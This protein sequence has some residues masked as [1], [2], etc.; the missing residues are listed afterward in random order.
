MKSPFAAARLAALT[1]LALGAPALASAADVPDIK[2]AV[3][4]S[5]RWVRSTQ[6]PQNGSY[7]GSAE[8][9]AWVL[10]AL[11]QSPR[12]YV[13][14]DGPFIARAVDFLLAA[15][16][17]DGSLG[18]GADQAQAT[19]V[20]AAAFGGMTTEETQAGL[21]RALAWLGKAGVADPFAPLVDAA[22][23][24]DAMLARANELLARQADGAWDG[25]Q[26]KVRATAE[27]IVE[28][29]GYY[30]ALKPPATK[31]AS[32]PLPGFDAA[33]RD[34]VEQARLRGA[35]FLQRLAD[36]GRFGAPGTPDCGLTAMSIA[37]LQTLPEP[38][39][40]AM[41]QTIDAGLEW[42][43]SLQ[44]PNGAIHDGKLASYNTSAS[45]LA[46]A[47]SAH[48]DA[49][50]AI[51]RGRD[52]LLG[53]QADAGEGYDEDHHYFGGIGYGGDERPDLSNLQMALEALA[54]SGLEQDHEGFQN[55]LKFLQRCQNRS[56]SNDLYLTQGD[57][58]YVAGDDG[59]ASYM[60]GN[61][62]AGY[63]E[64]ADG[65]K[66]ARSY[67]SMSYA[68]LKGLIFAGVPKDDPRMQACF[69]WIQKNYSLDVNPGFEAVSDP[70]AAYQGLF[71]YFHVM[72]RA[73]DLYGTDRIVTSDGTSHAWR[74]ELCG[75]LLALQSR[76]DGS[77]L[78]ENSPR[79]WEGNPLLAT[80]Y[81]LLTLDAALPE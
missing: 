34:A 51:R 70:R 9:T 68:L 4:R 81:A 27:T 25:P 56:E 6:D 69:E 38:R 57:T 47:G 49:S 13:P 66:V 74:N 59:G 36:E 18:S 52:F 67:G 64:L 3:D 41:Q 12:H 42:L 31:T 8:T 10:C 23:E 60:P 26:G 65:R 55:A 78:N 72:A 80:A 40:E 54:A 24:R 29:S 79:W 17:E 30:T 2:G 1:L 5:I 32:K 35:E 16:N 73:L 33:N 76:T 39:P 14:S 19:R 20:L 28:L 22:S 63:V 44:Q 21:G 62:P 53:L 43:L 75:R 71:Y 48:P 77:W 11:A 45:I 15:Q 58:V 7:G 61:S 50:A 37:A 46:L